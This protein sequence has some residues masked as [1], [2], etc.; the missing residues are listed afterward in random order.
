MR[1]MICS[2][3]TIWYGRIT[4]SIRSAVSTQYRVRMFSNVC[5]AKKVLAKPVRSSIGLFVASAHQLVKSKLFEVLR[6]R[7][8]PT[9]FAEVLGPDRVAVVLRQRAVRDDEQLH[10]LEET[11]SRPRSCP[12]DS[13]R[14]G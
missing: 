5:L 14:S 1:R 4:S 6:A 2:V 12:A 11:R 13:G 9:S 3:A 8:V 10:V 7:F